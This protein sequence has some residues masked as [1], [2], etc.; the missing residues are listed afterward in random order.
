M[1]PCELATAPSVPQEHSLGTG[2]RTSE[3]KG[4]NSKFDS[5]LLLIV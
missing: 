4:M 2:E 3:S 1:C 5:T